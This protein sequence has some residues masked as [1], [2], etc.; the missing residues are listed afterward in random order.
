MISLI[1]AS[2]Q[3][4]NAVIVKHTQN[5]TN[6]I[7]NP[8]QAEMAVFPKLTNAQIYS[9]D[10]YHNVFITQAINDFVFNTG[11][12]SIEMKADFTRTIGI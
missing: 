12:D 5:S 1:F 4:Q 2:C 11:N 10:I 3:K 6:S 9:I 7:T 8:A